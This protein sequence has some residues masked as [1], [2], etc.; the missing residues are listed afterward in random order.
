MT[1][2]G[3]HA[4]ILDTVDRFCRTISPA[5]VVRRDAEH[6][7]P[8]DFIP[9]LAELGL[10]RVTVPGREGGLGLPWIGIRRHRHD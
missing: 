8:Q 7:P 5:D 6:V 2:L 3:E 9:K 1:L 10:T 4:A